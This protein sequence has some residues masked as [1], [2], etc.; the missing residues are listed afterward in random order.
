MLAVFEH[1]V[2]ESLTLGGAEVEVLEEVGDAGEEADAV[3]AARFGL[4]EELVDELATGSASFDV[5][6]DD[7]GADL[8]EVWAVDV[9]GCAAEELMGVGFDDGEG[10]APDARR[11]E[12]KRVSDR[13]GQG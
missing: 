12:G 3:D 9:E 2:G 5:G 1:L 13:V 10:A 4:A 8:G 6:T 7:N 11:A